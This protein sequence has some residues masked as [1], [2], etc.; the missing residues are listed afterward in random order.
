MSKD[1][2]REIIETCLKKEVSQEEL[3]KLKIR[4][5]REYSLNRVPRNSEILEAASK[6]EKKILKHI[7]LKKPTRS[8]SGV[9]VVAVMPP[10]APCPHGKCSYCPQGPN[11][12]RS[13]TGKEPATMRAIRNNYDPYLQ[14][15]NRLAQLKAIGHPIEKVE[16]IVMGGTFTAQPA[17]K[18][19]AFVKGCFEAMAGRRFET[20]EEAKKAVEKT[21]IRPVGITFETRPDWA[22]EEQ[23]NE[24]LKL[25]VTRVEVGVQNPDDSIY[26]AVD[27]GHT[28][29]DVIEST[30]LLKDSGLKINYHMML[31]LPGSDDQKDIKAFKKI[32]EDPNFRPDMIKIYPTLV[33]RG[34]KLYEQ[35][36]RREYKPITS[37]H[38]AD[39]I[40][41]IKK[42]VPRW[43]RIMRIQRDIPANLI[44]S[45]VKRSDLRELVREKLVEKG[46]ECK[47]IR[48]REVGHVFRK[49]GLLPKDIEIKTIE[50]E[51]SGGKEYFISAE[52]FEQDILIGYLRLRIPSKKVFRPEIDDSTAIIRELHV[53]GPEVAIG[54]SA[55]SLEFQHRGYGKQ[56]LKKAEEIAL[57]NKKDK[58]LVLSGIGAKEYYRSSG[59]T[60][61][62]AYV[63]KMLK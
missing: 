26:K 19:E 27:R 43:V 17:E 32:F 39:L 30:Q 35:W 25:G 22:K 61:A 54:K 49:R 59:Y 33:I 51:A 16:L 53:Y 34:T 56:L 29:K 45:G 4:I 48:C 15:K 13:Y 62:G 41:E 52:D 58:I 9:S 21:E 63:G 36:K 11:A 46:V 47:C 3:E 10:P 37:E 31:G 28:V 1:Y 20:F 42:F 12:P 7:L 18:Q 2:L 44:D 57:K 8:I 5:S 55:S 38:A 6:E 50:Y 60:N 40:V 14:V 23:I 24:M